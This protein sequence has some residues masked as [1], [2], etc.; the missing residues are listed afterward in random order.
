MVVTAQEAAAV[1]STQAAVGAGA[2]VSAGASLLSMS[3]PV[4]IFS[5][6][7][8]FQLMYFLIVSG[9]YLSDGVF[10]VI[11]GMS[12]GM[13]DFNFI[14][15]EK[16]KI[17]EIIYKCLAFEQPN[18]LLNNIGITSGSTFMN[19]LKSILVVCIFIWMHALIMWAYYKCKSMDDRN[20]WRKFWEK[21]FE[22]FTFS[23]Y[24]RLFIQAFIIILLS[25][26]SEIY[27]LRVY[28]R[29]EI[30]SYI[31]NL[32]IFTSIFVFYGL[33][34]MQIK[35]AHPVLKPKRQFYFV[36]LFAGLKNKTS[37]RIYPAIF[38]GQRILTWM[39]VIMLSKINLTA[40]IVVI[41]AIQASAMIYLLIARP[42]LIFKDLISE[43]LSQFVVTL[44]SGLLIFYRT[45]DKWS[46]ITNWM[47]IGIIMTS[48]LISTL[49]SL[50]DLIVMIT[51]KIKKWWSNEKIENFK[52]NQDMTVS[53]N[54]PDF[55]NAISR[56]FEAH[57]IR[58][59]QKSSFVDTV[60]FINNLYIRKIIVEFYEYLKMVIF[61]RAAVHPH[62]IY[63]PLSY[64]RTCA[65]VKLYSPIPA[66]SVIPL[67]DSSPLIIS[68][69]MLLPSC[70]HRWRPWPVEINYRLVRTLVHMEKGRRSWLFSY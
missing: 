9:V 70:L 10:S 65:I 29:V 7:N 39:V 15:I 52:N 4:A 26:F 43:C 67:R 12:F 53:R 63:P 13:F 22:I 42:Y 16:I 45:K 49:V 32:F 28:N 50:I 18:T 11:T 37:S 59:E 46:S 61:T 55:A 58:E 30:I 51:K 36:E 17:F 47:F 57:I 68:T 24:I 1:K 33:W 54:A 27:E 41:T 64:P 44:F 5:M 66:S 20:C 19:M 62:S 60:K 21:L 2:S 25:S 31:I 69:M 14:K 48:S 40:K 23:I 38:L 3:S 35:K 6:I 8:Q 34:I 56:E